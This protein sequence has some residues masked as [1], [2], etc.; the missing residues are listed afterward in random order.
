[1]KKLT[2]I[3]AM[4][5]VL[6]V[7]TLAQA[8]LIDMGNGV[9]QDDKGTLAM[10]DDQFWIQDLNVFV[11]L[12]YDGQK[13]AIS[14]LGNMG[15]AD[16]TSWHMATQSDMSNLFGSYGWPDLTSSFVPTRVEPGWFLSW[17]GRYDVIVTGYP[18]PPGAH[19]EAIMHHYLDG[20]IPEYDGG[21]GVGVRDD[22]LFPGAFATAYTS[23]PVP[24]PEPT[25]MLL[26]G[27]GLIG[28]AG[29]RRR[30]QK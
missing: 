15:I 21:L 2:L 18:N 7:V 26:L 3:A 24:T 19:T 10:T 14:N 9:T 22:E 23:P 16:I 11:G 5:M 30:F 6:G 28:L 4:L 20:R 13:T 27:L 12:T 25:T 17:K 8:S 1:M 29:V